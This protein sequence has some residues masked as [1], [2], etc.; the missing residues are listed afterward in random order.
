MTT[1]NKIFNLLM[2]L[3]MLSFTACSGGDSDE[4]EVVED[5]VQ[6]PTKIQHYDGSTQFVGDLEALID[7][8]CAVYAMRMAYYNIVSNDFKT[9]Q[10]YVAT[11]ADINANTTSM[12]D[13]YD[14]AATIVDK[15]DQYEAAFQRLEDEGVLENTNA[16][17]QTRGWLS[18]TFSFVFG[19]KK[20]Q[21]VGRKSVLAVIQ[22]SGWQNDDNNLQKLFNAVDPK[23]RQGYSRRWRRS[24]NRNSISRLQPGKA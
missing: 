13:F 9:G 12:Y 16:S 11:P 24:R 17:R 14:I 15:G 5:T 23:R 3:C 1:R 22:Q 6:N 10:A 20:S 21:E 4:T 2:M 8:S 19:L 7:Y 18:D